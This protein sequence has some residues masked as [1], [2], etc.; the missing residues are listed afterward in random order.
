MRKPRTDSPLAKWNDE[1]H[2]PQC[3]ELYS[4]LRTSTYAEAVKWLEETHGIITS[5]GGLSRWYKRQNKKRLRERLRDSIATSKV[6]DKKVDA[7]VID[8]RMGTALQSLFFA[9]V[10]TGDTKAILEFAD[11]AMEHSKSQREET[12]LERTL[13]AER[14]ARTLREELGHANAQ[15][16]ELRLALANIGRVNQADPAEVMAKVDEFL[17]VKKPSK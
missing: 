13:K 9:A 17:G 6:F 11:A 7:A 4:I 1:A 16:E 14:E 8:G 15:I 5:V 10:S 12:K 2:R 3:D